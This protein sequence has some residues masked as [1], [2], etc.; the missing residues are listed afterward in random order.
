[1]SPE[2]QNPE[3]SRIFYGWF[4]LAGVAIVIFIVGGAFV[5]S[6]GPLLPELE[7][8]S[9]YDWG[10]AEI[11][12]ALTL[13]ILAFGLPSP[14]FGILVNKYGPRY[15]IIVGNAIAALG[16]AGVYLAQEVWHLYF[17]Y[18]VTG[19]GGGFGGYIEEGIDSCPVYII[20]WGIVDVGANSC[21]GPVGYLFG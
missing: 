7:L 5:H 16:L 13:G 12:L 17:F 10:R 21:K 4:A 8:I 11:A 15:T 18:I 1:M 19:L 14:L 20:L 3:N 6:F 9:E 2:N